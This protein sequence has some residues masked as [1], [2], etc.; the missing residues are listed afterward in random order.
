[1][2]QELLDRPEIGAAV[3]Q[4]GGEGVAQGV[5]VGWRRGA[6]VEDPAHVAVGEGAAAAVPQQAVALPRRRIRVDELVADAVE[7]IRR[8]RSG[9][10]DVTV[11]RDG[12]PVLEFRGRSRALTGPPG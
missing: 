1:V 7:R 5:R 10:Y 8:G 3:E 9:L 4:V 6:P 11:R 12:E 2:A